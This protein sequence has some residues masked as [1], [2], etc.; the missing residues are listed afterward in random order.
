MIQTAERRSPSS[1]LR[2][3][4]VV[5]QVYQQ[6]TGKQAFMPAC[7]V[8]TE[9]HHQLDSAEEY[10][11]MCHDVVGRYVHHQPA[12]GEGEIGWL[13]MYE[14]FYGGLPEV[15]FRDTNGVLDKTRREKYL[16]AGVFYASWDCTPY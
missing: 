15:W 7:P 2:R 12:Q 8:D 5:A 13:G 11:R 14:K 1:E 4:F 9:W 6:K 16:E 10:Q 3:F